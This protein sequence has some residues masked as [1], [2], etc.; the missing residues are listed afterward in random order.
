MTWPHGDPDAVAR[1]LL[2]EPRFRDALTPPG[3]KSWWE[4]VL[5]AIGRWWHQ[6]TGG[7]GKVFGNGAVATIVGALILIAVI[8]ALTWVIWRI[9]RRPAGRARR[10]ASAAEIE[11][12]G[13][14]ADA[15]GLRD[16]AQRAY[17]AGRY[18]D[19]AALFWSAALRCLDE[20]G[21]VRYDPART[22]GEWRR[23]V[24]NAAFD[25]FAR[26]AV[27]ALFSPSGV[28]AALA[29]RMRDGFDAAVGA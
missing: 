17:E 18:R 13:R 24:R 27:V 2:A 6:L 25:A 1:R 28:D 15:A 5:E 19:A 10:F 16:A 7:L 8:L 23:A 14:Q 11:R 20:R 4:Y 3:A 26:D 9:V 22:P 21:S 29:A 12:L